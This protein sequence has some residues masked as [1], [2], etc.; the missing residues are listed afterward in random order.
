MTR[1][2][3]LT[4][5]GDGGDEEEKELA[6]ASTEPATGGDHDA[7]EPVRPTSRWSTNPQ[8]CTDCG[9]RIQ[10]AW[11]DDGRLLCADCKEW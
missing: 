4:E 10:R 2:A 1:D 9:T 6:A 11:T 3:S 7:P 8:P 5:F